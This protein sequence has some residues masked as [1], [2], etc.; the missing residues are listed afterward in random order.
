MPRNSFLFEGA[1]PSEC[2]QAKRTPQNT[3]G[4]VLLIDTRGQCEKVFIGWQQAFSLRVV[5]VSPRLGSLTR[6][7]SFSESRVLKVG[8]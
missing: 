6:D 2:S 4:I 7:G 1:H 8:F 3:A 5:V